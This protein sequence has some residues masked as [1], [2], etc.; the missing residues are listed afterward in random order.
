MSESARAR[1]KARRIKWAVRAGLVALRAL[2]STWRIKEVNGDVIRRLRGRHQP[3]ILAFWH[4]RMLPLLWHHRGQGINILV[5]EH[6]DGEIIARV[7]EALGC[8]TI[9]GSTSRGAEWALLRLIRA[10]RD[11]GEIAITPDGP[12]GPAESFA[13]GALV[14]AQRS[15]APV[16]ALAAGASSTWRLRSWDGFMVPKPFARVT[17][18]YG[19]PEHFTELTAREAAAQ[20]PRMQNALVRLTA[21][22]DV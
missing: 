18:A 12:R 6:G 2:A 16:V 17:I 22:T 10:V 13:S 4:G 21:T 15:G 8:R 1:R 19:Q 5:S 11:G 3:F 14:V 9:R 7:A 20:A